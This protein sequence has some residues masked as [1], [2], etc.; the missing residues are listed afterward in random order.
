MASSKAKP[1][2]SR[3]FFW[4]TVF[5]VILFGGY[6]AGWFYVA[7]QVESLVTSVIAGLNKDGTSADCT[8]PTAR[9]FPFRIGLFCDT[10]RFEDE[11]Q[12]LKA[13]AQAFRSAA[14]VYDPFHIVAEVDSPARI[15]APQFGE[16]GFDWSNLKASARL[17]TDFPES[18]SIVT[19]GMAARAGSAAGLFNIAHAEGHLRQNGGDLDLAGNFKDAT[20]D[21]RLT[22]GA[23]LPPLTGEA[24]LTIKNG[25]DFVRFGTGSL[26]G[27]SGTIRTLTL[28]TG[29]DA[30]MSV[31]GPF[32][33]S[34]EGLLDADFTLTIRNPRQ[35]SA[36]LVA[37]F[38]AQ[39]DQIRM[40]FTGLAA[41][42]DNPSMPLKIKA[43]N[44]TLGF[45]PLGK[46]PPL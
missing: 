20:F 42:G 40:S 9:G 11:A 19:D 15:S 37:A 46:L 18:V 35:L 45:I 8:R 32:A 17:S 13:S 4:L 22:N 43:G 24:D 25:V 10:V 30:G 44:A 1:N 39:A 5:I 21:A 23:K 34:A 36:Q 41:M 12:G 2:S 6:S 38:P 14:Q 33:V 31:S 26:R 28:S 29:G 3:R 27:Q 16:L 7:G